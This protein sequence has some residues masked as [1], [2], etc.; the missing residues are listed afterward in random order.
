MNTITKSMAKRS[1]AVLGGVGLALTTLLAPSAQAE[2]LKGEFEL[3][4][5]NDCGSYATIKNIPNIEKEGAPA[6]TY[7]EEGEEAEIDWDITLNKID[8]EFSILY[9]ELVFY[10][11]TPEPVRI[12][13]EDTIFKQSS[14]GKEV[15]GYPYM[16]TTQ[17]DPHINGCDFGSTKATTQNDIAAKSLTTKMYQPPTSIEVDPGMYLKIDIHATEVPKEEGSEYEINFDYKVNGEKQNYSADFTAVYDYNLQEEGFNMS[18]NIN[19]PYFLV[20]DSREA[21]YDNI[22][23]EEA[24]VL[25]WS[26]TEDYPDPNFTKTLKFS[27][28]VG[29]ELKGGECKVYP[30]EATLL[31]TSLHQPEYTFSNL[32]SENSL[33]PEY[34]FYSAMPEG[35]DNEEYGAQPYQTVD[36]EV[37]VCVLKEVEP[38]EPTLTPGTCGEESTVLL[39]EVEGIKYT[40]TRDGDTVT[41]TAE[42]EEG[43]TFPEEAT[44]EWTFEITV[45][46]CDVQVKK[47]VKDKDGEWEDANILKDSPTVK[48]G[49]KVEYKITVEN[50]GEEDL[51]DVKVKDSLFPT[52]NKVFE[53]IKIGEMEEYEF[54]VEL[55]EELKTKTDGEA[56]CYPEGWTEKE[57]DYVVNIATVEAFAGEDEV[58][59]CDPAGVLV[60]EEESTPSTTTPPTAPEESQSGEKPETKPGSKGTDVSKTGV[61][62]KGLILGGALA[63]ISLGLGSFFL[64]RKRA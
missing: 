46:E 34:P 62:S 8:S 15:E 23:F 17:Y 29:S 16:W 25:F 38:V 22:T 13:I 50:T 7:I 60:E 18:E 53:E 41:V 6:L 56:V 35:W 20:L 58:R 11:E 2:I 32:L 27:E 26:Y 64:T 12:D 63:L 31:S 57:S 40:E 55:T 42:A 33:L 1:L 19:D 4:K 59:D 51:R 37:E 21:Y 14:T 43:F 9:T 30:N 28:K 10:N 47:Y 54:T 44:T 5:F 61:D 45:K 24:Q 3:Q 49:D 52:A 39:P 36:A 48:N